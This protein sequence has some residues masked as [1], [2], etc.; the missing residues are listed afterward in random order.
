MSLPG[1]RRHRVLGFV[2]SIDRGW[3]RCRCIPGA[4]IVLVARVPLSVKF[5][6]GVRVCV[7]ERGR[8]YDKEIKWWTVRLQ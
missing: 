1:G 2:V 6:G 3:L 8:K 5:R 4:V 7:R